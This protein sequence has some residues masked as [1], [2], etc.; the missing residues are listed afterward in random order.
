MCP[1]ASAGFTP[2]DVTSSNNTTLRTGLAFQVQGLCFSYGAPA[3]FP[4]L[5]AYTPGELS[6]FGWPRIGVIF[7]FGS[8]AD[9]Y[10][11]SGTFR[12]W[13]YE[14]HEGKKDVDADVCGSCPCVYT[15]YTT[16]HHFAS[17][18]RTADDVASLLVGGLRRFRESGLLFEDGK[19][20]SAYGQEFRR[21][22]GLGM[23]W[24]RT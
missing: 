11:C 10:D 4:S 12:S 21:T 8:L 5:L 23:A 24:T 1:L 18:V 2:Q 17:W 20:L 16:L 22:S 9:C 13:Y 7:G 6:G 3:V 14:C 15:H 19:D